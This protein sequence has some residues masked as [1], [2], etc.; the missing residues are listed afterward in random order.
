MNNIIKKLCSLL[1]LIALA[2]AAGWCMWELSGQ[3]PVDNCYLGYFTGLFAGKPNNDG[4]NG[5]NYIPYNKFNP[6]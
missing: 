3:M 2:D 5:R 1:I 4:F 6:E